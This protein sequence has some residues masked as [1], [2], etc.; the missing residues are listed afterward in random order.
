MGRTTDF[1]VWRC[2]LQSYTSLPRGRPTSQLTCVLLCLAGCICPAAG[3]EAAE[4]K[5][6]LAVLQQELAAQTAELEAEVAAGAAPGMRLVGRQGRTSEGKWGDACAACQLSALSLPCFLHPPSNLPA[7]LTTL[8]GAALQKHIAAGERRIKAQYDAYSRH[9]A[10]AAEAE[11]ALDLLS[12]SLGQ[13]S[14]EAQRQAATCGH[15]RGELERRAAVVTAAKTKLEA[16]RVRVAMEGQQLGS[17][18]QKVGGRQGCMGVGW[19]AGGCGR[20][21]QR[22]VVGSAHMP[23]CMPVGDLPLTPLSINVSQPQP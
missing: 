18:Q 12:D 14:D 3:Q 11:D 5:A 8:V 9:Q 1:G 7:P 17:L 21:Q 4:R 19:L 23:A 16:A 22:R 20:A 15:L 2:W 10:A 6:R 13:A